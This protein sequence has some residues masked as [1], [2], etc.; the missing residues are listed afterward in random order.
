M[1]PVVPTNSVSLDDFNETPTQVL[2]FS[3]LL[4]AFLYMSGDGEL[5]LKSPCQAVEGDMSLS[6]FKYC[7]RTEGGT[8]LCFYTST[9][10]SRALVMNA[11]DGMLLSIA[12][13]KT[14]RT[15]VDSLGHCM[16]F[17]ERELNLPGGKSAISI[18]SACGNT[19]AQPLVFQGKSYPSTASCDVTAGPFFQVR[20]YSSTIRYFSVA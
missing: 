15:I 12:M 11:H 1:P 8:K 5:R 18:E 2:I 4:Q 16:L 13:P 20:T 14:R 9:S 19:T 6:L 10:E 7:E 3:V 17:R